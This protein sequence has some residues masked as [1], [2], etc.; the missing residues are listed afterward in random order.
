MRIAC[1][2]P[3]TS[4][5]VPVIIVKLPARADLTYPLQSRRTVSR[6][7][8][9][10]EGF[11]ASESASAEKAVVRVSVAKTESVSLAATASRNARW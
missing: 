1:M 7:A 9:S 3:I 11:V 8:V 10:A 6:S 2:V 4:S 5:A